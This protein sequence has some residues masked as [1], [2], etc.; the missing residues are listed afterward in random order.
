VLRNQFRGD[1][2]FG[3]GKKSP[4]LRHMLILVFLYEDAENF[5]H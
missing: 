3:H 4:Q 5:H 1:G 2:G